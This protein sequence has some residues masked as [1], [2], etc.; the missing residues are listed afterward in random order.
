MDTEV[1][2]SNLKHRKWTKLSAVRTKPDYVVPEYDNATPLFPIERQPVLT[3]NIVNSLNS[4]KRKFI[5]VQSLYRYLHEISDIETGFIY[6]TAIRIAMSQ[7]FPKV[8][9]MDA[10]TVA[11]D[12]VYHAYC[13]V[14]LI[15][16]L[17]QQLNIAPLEF[18][19]TQFET[20]ILETKRILSPTLHKDFEI[21]AVS[22]SESLIGSEAGELSKEE[23][24]HKTV[25][26][27][28]YDHMLDEVRHARIFVEVLKSHWSS[29]T[30]KN[31]T[32]FKEVL[33]KFISAIFRPDTQMIF[34][35]KVLKAVGL[36]EA[37]VQQIINDTYTENNPISSDRDRKVMNNIFKFLDKCN[38]YL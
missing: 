34:D 28:T 23:N 12:E 6:E 38:I 21:V 15:D 35:K 11:I 36:E 26:D 24:L 10:F 22:I 13:A 2:R 32:I 4:E 27:F 30:P 33:P 19:K 20:A 17:Q 1:V 31:Q 8:V 37:K 18:P 29:L 5:L 14:D 9:S 7:N 16:Q 25:R 3:H